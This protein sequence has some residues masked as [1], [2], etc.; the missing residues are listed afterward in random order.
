MGVLVNYNDVLDFQCVLRSR[1]GLPKNGKEHKFPVPTTELTDFLQVAVEERGQVL[2]NVNRKEPLFLDSIENDDKHLT[3]YGSIGSDN[4]RFERLKVAP[5]RAYIVV[6]ADPRES[7]AV[8]FNRSLEPAGVP[9]NGNKECVM[10]YPRGSMLSYEQHRGRMLEYLC[11]YDDVPSESFVMFDPE[12]QD[13]G[14]AVLKRVQQRVIPAIRKKFSLHCSEA[15]LNALA[16]IDGS[17]V[18]T[19]FPDI[20]FSVK[21]VK[22]GISDRFAAGVDQVFADNLPFYHRTFYEWTGK[23]KLKV[24]VMVELPE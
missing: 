11:M 22:T 8:L 15:E 3:L 18:R 19:D 20:S 17:Y 13:L 4:G 6:D 2:F 5:D 14:R 12:R 1:Y 23:R 10:F 21:R 16:R 24:S 7:F 9:E